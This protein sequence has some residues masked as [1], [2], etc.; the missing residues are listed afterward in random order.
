MSM[1]SKV[2]Y[3]TYSYSVS[4]ARGDIGTAAYPDGSP[5]A[6]LVHKGVR[7]TFTNAGGSPNI[8][9]DPKP[10]Y[11]ENGA[12][13]NRAA[14]A[15]LTWASGVATCYWLVYEADADNTTPFVWNNP[16]AGP[17]QLTNGTVTIT[18]PYAL[19]TKRINATTVDIYCI[20]YDGRIVFRVRSNGTNGDTYT[21]QTGY[22][23]FPALSFG[24]N[25]TYGVDL[26][27]IG[28]S[29]YAL[30]NSGTNLTANYLNSTVVQLDLALSTPPVAVNGPYGSSASGGTAK[31][32]FSIQAYN[33]GTDDHLLVT[34]VGGPQ[35]D[36][37]YPPNYP[38][39][40]NPGSRIQRV[41]PGT[42]AVT[43]L[44]RSAATTSEPGTDQFDFRAL[45]FSAD[46]SQAYILAGKYN[47]SF[48]SFNYRLYFTDMG[49]ILSS[50]SA[51]MSS[52]VSGLTAKVVE[53]NSAANGYLWGLLYSENNVMT[54]F[55][56]GEDLAIY[57]QSVLGGQVAS[58]GG[59]TALSTFTAGQFPGLNFVTIYED[60]AAPAPRAL[61]GYVAP[62]F[63][64]NSP[65]ALAERERFLKEVAAANEK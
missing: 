9:P 2:M 49:T 43:D 17:V 15:S 27:I 13:L 4:P 30:F 47:T 65:A 52:L 36:Q 10:L 21:P 59:I 40:W 53:I 31:N 57:D 62:A 58:A 28:D 45:T 22:Y 60:E 48:A 35:L 61:K 39:N 50:S 63:A 20:D 46:G 37:A 23:Q 7:T 42:L 32:S 64:S 33:D 29:V 6:I 56:K 16:V 55:V 5:P 14:V 26:E 19:K 25:Q 24:S 18:N 54:W 1:T 44:L 41:D 51:L 11:F 34:A 3:G 38:Q 8:G 12:G